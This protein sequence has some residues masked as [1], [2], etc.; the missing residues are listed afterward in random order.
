MANQKYDEV[1]HT[2]NVRDKAG[3]LTIQCDNVRSLV[4]NEGNKQWVWLSIYGDTDEL[5]CVSVEPHSCMGVQGLRQSSL[6]VFRQ[7]VLAYTGFEKL[8]SA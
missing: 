2:K 7:Y 6:P 1:P 5:V 3:R 8:T 4:G